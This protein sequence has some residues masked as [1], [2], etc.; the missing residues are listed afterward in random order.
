MSAVDAEP[1][2]PEGHHPARRSDEEA[3]PAGEVA[4]GEVAGDEAADPPGRAGRW[5]VEAGVAA[6]V[7]ATATQP[8]YS[9][10]QNTYLVRA[11]AAVDGGSLRTDRLVRSADPTRA[12]TWLAR[13]ALATGGRPLLHL[14]WV[15][16]AAVFYAA[17]WW[18]TARTRSPLRT[19]TWAAGIAL[20]VAPI[21]QVQ[22]NRVLDRL[23]Q[24]GPLPG[25]LLAGVAN[26]YGLGSV[27]QPSVGAV[28]LLV[29]V[30]WWVRRR[31]WVGPTVLLLLGALIHPTYLLA[32][33]LLLVAMVGAEALED[34]SGLVRR[35]SPAAGVAVLGAL[36]VALANAPTFS[37]LGGPDAAEGNRILADVRIPN[38]SDPGRWFGLPT[39][40]VVAVVAVGAVLAWRSGRPEQRRLARFLGLAGLVVGLASVVAAAGGPSARLAFPWRASVVIVPLGTAAL[41]AALADG[42]VAAAGRFRPAVA[43]PALAGAAVLA[44]VVAGWSGARTTRASFRRPPVRDPIVAAVR[45]A[46]PAGE[47]LV[48]REAEGVRLNAEVAVYVDWKNNPNEPAEVVRWYRRLLEDD[49]AQADAADLCALVDREGF[50]WVVV[51]PTVAAG[52]ACL[53]GWDRHEAGDDVLAVRPAG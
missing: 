7:V 52:A 9:G 14:L 19:A 20:L 45:A 50:G 30:A 32:A 3:T 41:V 24:D 12:F 16:A 42:L 39:V 48:P 44:L 5:A 40:V 38:H 6:L 43:R 22:W 36:V 26:Q 51:P 53:E 34:R 31:T 13:I 11:V 17:L 37:S 1:G 29:G 49:A 18:A 10:N 2:L 27:L 25:D 8:L 35:A 4:G 15:V 28:A 47:G 21:S 23:G 46:A 33:A